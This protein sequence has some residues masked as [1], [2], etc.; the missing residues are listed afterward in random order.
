[1]NI[2]LLTKVAEWLENGAPHEDTGFGFDIMYWNNDISNLDLDFY[3]PKPWNSNCKTVCCIAGAAVQF[4]DTSDSNNIL[5]SAQELL[6][7]NKTTS[8]DLFEPWESD[9]YYNLT[10][11]EITPDLS[12][13]VIRNLIKT[14]KVDWSI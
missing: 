14:G 4:S 13:K 3:E 11:E 1:M 8:T 12:A 7:L 9:T 2:E 5:S 10:F 6:G